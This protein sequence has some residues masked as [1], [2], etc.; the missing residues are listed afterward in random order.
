MKY[1]CTIGADFKVKQINLEENIITLQIWDTSGSELYKRLSAF[2][3][4]T[5]CCV[6]IFDLTNKTSFDSLEGIRKTFLDLLYPKEQEK[7]PFVLL[8]NKSDKID[9]RKVTE[10]D[11][12][13][14]CEK[15]PNITY[16]ETSAKNNTNIDEAFYKIAE[17]ASK[18][19]FLENGISIPSLPN[20][21]KNSKEEENEVKGSTKDGDEETE[22]DNEKLK[23][24]NTKLKEELENYKK[25][26][27]EN[28][29]L[30]YQIFFQKLDINYLKKQI[31]ILKNKK[32]KKNGKNNLEIFFVPNDNSYLERFECLETD[33]FAE[34]EEK[35]YKKHEELRNTNNIF[36]SNGI[37][38]ERFKTM[39][40]N[41][42]NNGNIIRIYQ[43]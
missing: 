35:L 5:K 23:K 15:H 32:S 20:N 4:N 10:N 22:V 6:L 21:L 36:I 8:G 39:S 17:L 34:I 29:C 43:E 16:F 11:I 13:Q 9:E 19:Y 14:F 27:E 33:T 42:I 24:E 26:V 41:K 30:K 7:Y 1:K 25:I 28:K 2:Y 3:R 38:I 37:I 12:K 18:Q 40:E 31:Q